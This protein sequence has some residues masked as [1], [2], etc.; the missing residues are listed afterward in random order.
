LNSQE[1]DNVEKV[2]CQLCHSAPEE[3]ADAE[4]ADQ[5][6]AAR[7]AEIEAEHAEQVKAAR[8]RKKVAQEKSTKDVLTE[9]WH[10]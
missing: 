1:T 5:E 2:A 7:A 9:L 6:T 10:V 8:A 3:A 4:H